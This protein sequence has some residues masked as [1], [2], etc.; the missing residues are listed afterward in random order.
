MTGKHGLCTLVAAASL[1]LASVAVAQDDETEETVDEAHDAGHMTQPSVEQGQMMAMPGMDNLMMPAM[2]AAR[3][4]K[5]FG[6][7][8][9][10]ACHAIHDL[11]GLDAP[12]I[13]AHSM[14]TMMNPFEFAARMWRGASTMIYM[15]EE[16]GEQIEFTG[17]ELADLIAF[18]HDEEEQHRFSLADIPPEIMA[19]MDHSHGDADEH[20]ADGAEHNAGDEHHD[21][22]VEHQAGDEHADV[23]HEHGVSDEHHDDGV[24]H[25]AGDEHA[26]VGDN[27]SVLMPAEEIGHEHGVSDEHHDDG[28]EH[29]A[30]DEHADVGHEHGVTD[31]HHDDGAEHQAGDEHPDD[32]DNVSV[33]MPAEEIGHEHGVSDEH[34][35][36]GVEHHAGDEHH[37]DGAEHRAG[38][39]H[40]DD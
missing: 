28:V 32:G 40:H 22:G 23:G 30:G 12:P 25:Q 26:D 38:D 13:D 2:D 31:E 8:G 24:E 36:D 10:I 18:V 29:H 21:D 3:G 15:Q 4:R 6:S 14:D 39:E 20:H 34:H 35:D 16:L 17:K 33:L 1:L 19:I 7:K 5:L 37:D 9:C 27:V 11:G